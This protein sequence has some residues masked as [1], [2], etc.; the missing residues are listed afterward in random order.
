MCIRV[1]EFRWK[2]GFKIVEWNGKEVKRRN[3]RHGRT[4]RWKMVGMWEAAREKQGMIRIQIRRVRR[5][6][7]KERY[8]KRKETRPSFKS[9]FIDHTWYKNIDEIIMMCQIRTKDKL[10]FFASFSSPIKTPSVDNFDT[11]CDTNL[12]L[13]GI[14]IYIYFFFLGGGGKNFAQSSTRENKEVLYVENDWLD[15]R[16]KDRKNGIACMM[17]IYIVYKKYRSST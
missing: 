4:I 15:F 2:S 14:E 9:H 8:K 16:G 13:L 12:V 3:K 5:R 10:P 1:L 7:P 6:I 17:Y 11:S